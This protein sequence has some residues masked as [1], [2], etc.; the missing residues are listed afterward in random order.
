VTTPHGWQPKSRVGVSL[1][2]GGGVADFTATGMRNTT[3]VAGY[4]EVRAAAGT[5]NW[6]AIEGMYNGSAQSI[7]G[8]GLANTGTLIRNGIET[9]GRINL[10]RLYAKETLLEP[11]M[12]GG[13]GW[14]IYSVTGTNTAAT[15]VTSTDNVFALPFGVGF[16]VGYHGLMF[17]GR[18]TY[19]PTFDSH[20]TTTNPNGD[21][22]LNNWNIGVELGYEF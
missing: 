21:F 9:T 6:W 13:V 1:S 4:W 5:R 2:A 17:D 7:S 8:L 15:D 3:G 12:F 10:L 20:L 16:G 22:N 11:Y 19:R 18:F 14:N